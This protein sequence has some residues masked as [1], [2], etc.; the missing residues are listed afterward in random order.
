[1]VYFFST[2]FPLISETL[3]ISPPVSSLLHSVFSSLPVDSGL[4]FPRLP[5]LVVASRDSQ[6]TARAKCRALMSSHECEGS[7]L[8]PPGGLYKYL[9]FRTRVKM[10]ARR[11]YDHIHHPGMCINSLPLQWRQ[12][13]AL[14]LLHLRLIPTCTNV[15]CFPG[16]PA[17]PCLD[18][19]TCLNLSSNFLPSTLQPPLTLR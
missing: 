8:A 16:P 12:V 6:R 4:L 3:V 15:W 2:P 7:A 1:M 5:S 14:T 18:A 11:R 9:L 10:T 19:S 17:P 13:C